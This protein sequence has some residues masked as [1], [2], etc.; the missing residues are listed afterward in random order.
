MIDGGMRAGILDER[1]RERTIT[2]YINKRKFRNKL[3]IPTENTISIFLLNREGDI[4][5]RCQGEL[6]DKKS[7]ELEKV[8][9]ELNA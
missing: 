6:N 3:D 1:K 2:L 5:W 8:L 4:L 7:S 9:F